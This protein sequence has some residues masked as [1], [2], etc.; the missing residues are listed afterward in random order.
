M[1]LLTTIKPRRDGTV[2]LRDSAG[3]AHLFQPD[4]NGSLVCEIDDEATLAIALR[5]GEFE[6]A[7]EADYGRA[8]ELLQGAAQAPQD[9]ED[10][11]EDED[12]GD[13][14]GPP[15][16]ANTPPAPAAPIK[17]GPGRPRRI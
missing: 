1:L 14:G 6:P 15:L 8:Q 3:R 16:E 11:D 7:N 5:S 10:E 17:R 4:L 13:P 2:V 9:G 12:E